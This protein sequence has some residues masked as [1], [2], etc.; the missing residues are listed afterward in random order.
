M[1]DRSAT[2]TQYEITRTMKATIVATGAAVGRIE[3][4]HINGKVMV[5]LA[6]SGD[7]GV[8]NID[9]MVEGFK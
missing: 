3:V 7:G 9:A 5:W 8:V 2:I 4:G 6:G 1:T